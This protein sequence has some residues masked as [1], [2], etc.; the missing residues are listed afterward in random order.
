VQ[1]SAA[2]LTDRIAA[3]DL[4]LFDHVP[5]QTAPNDRRVLLALHHALREAH[6]RFRYMEIGSHK[7]GS[8]QVL[9]RDPACER[10]VSIDSRPAVM[11]DNEQGTVRYADNTTARMRSLLGAV[12]DADL[13]KL[14]TIDASTED[15][16]PFP[17][18]PHVAFVDAEHT[19][20]AVLRD[21]RFSRECGARAIAFHDTAAIG[22]AIED[23]REEWGA[24]AHY[25]R[26]AVC[27]V[28]PEPLLAPL[29]ARVLPPSVPQPSPAPPAAPAADA[30]ARQLVGF[31][32]YAWSGSDPE[33]TRE[34][35]EQDLSFSQ[36]KTLLL[37]AE[38]DGTLPV[39]DVAERLGI[40][41][42]AAS[43]A[44]DSLVRRGL[45]ERAEDP[46]DRRMKQ[47]RTTGKGDRLMERLVAARIR[48]FERLL[49]GFTGTERRKLGDA[50]DEILARPEIARL[51]PRGRR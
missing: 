16:E 35:A 7:G 19:Y 22:Q 11:P 13:G 17:F 27:L 32:R 44:V 23:F 2:T 45:A 36:L 40:S 4:S 31:V 51:C 41:L 39:K 20:R 46:T 12:P 15:L 50:L 18:D 3:L 21:A 8:L 10:I 6:G 29:M 14:Q 28:E 43:R 25:Y 26:R 24:Q 1:V 37:L 9:V 49:D 48:S 34:V 5:S 47:V 38:H 33:F 30:L 42:P